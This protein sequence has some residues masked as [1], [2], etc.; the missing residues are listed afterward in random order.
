LFVTAAVAVAL[1]AAP[2]H[3]QQRQPT[4]PAPAARPAATPAPAPGT[5]IPLPD[6]QNTAKLVWS[7]LAA[8]DHA[9]KTGN[10]SVLRDL[11]T[12]SFQAN[13]NAAGLAGAFAR[14]REQRIDLSNTL[15]I[16]PSYEFAPGFVRPGLLRIRGSFAMRPSAILFDLLFQWEDGWRLEGIALMP[17]GMANQTPPR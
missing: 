3:A 17:Q 11:G 2:G 12:G 15:V 14:I 5:A 10:Y 16:A 4:R 8:V 9:N 6:P 13:N 7:T 1:T